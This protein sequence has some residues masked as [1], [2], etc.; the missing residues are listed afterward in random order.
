MIFP[1]VKSILKSM[2]YV[3]YD[4]PYELNIVGVRSRSIIPNRFDD[5]IHVFYKTRIGTWNYHIFKATT[6]PGTFW[7]EHPENPQG[8]AMLAGGQYV[9]AF[10]LGS[11]KGQYTALIQKKPV[12]VWRDYDRRATLD[13]KNGTKYTGMFGIQMHRAESQGSTK[14]VDKYSAG[15]QVFENANDFNLFIALC[16]QHEKLYGNTFT[17]TLLDFRA[18]RRETYRRIIMGAAAAG[19]LLWGWFMSRPEQPEKVYS[20]N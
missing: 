9:D 20:T 14:Y 2:G 12:T 10:E 11:H 3:L 7:L 16:L 4:R 6:D 19:T 8:T 15:C 13:F 1:R 5:E 18:L 17:Y